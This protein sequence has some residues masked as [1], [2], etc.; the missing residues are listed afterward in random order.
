MLG[1]QNNDLCDEQPLREWL[2][3]A[4]MFLLK[5]FIIVQ[6]HEFNN[7]EFILVLN[8]AV[9]YTYILGRSLTRVQA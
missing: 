1:S 3:P 4:K 7:Q 6:I 2:W 9:I 5:H 8:H